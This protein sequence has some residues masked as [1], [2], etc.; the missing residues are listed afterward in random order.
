MAYEV[1]KRLTSGTLPLQVEAYASNKGHDQG[2][3]DH[4]DSTKPCDWLDVNVIGHD[5]NASKNN[6]ERCREDCLKFVGMRDSP[7]LE[8][9]CS[10]EIETSDHLH[11]KDLQGY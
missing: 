5:R 3:R 2:D 9:Y 11:E 7:W 1:P 10:V 4:T 8:P 6:G